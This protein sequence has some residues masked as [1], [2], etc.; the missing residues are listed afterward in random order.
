MNSLTSSLSPCAFSSTIQE[1]CRCI[2]LDE[3]QSSCTSSLS[4]EA[5]TTS[6]RRFS[7]KL[8]AGATSSNAM[9]IDVDQPF[10]RGPPT[11]SS[12]QS[13]SRSASPVTVA[14]GRKS[15]YRLPFRSATAP[16]P[17]RSPSPDLPLP[18]ECAFPV[19]PS[20]ISRSVTP[21]T[22]K[23]PPERSNT[24]SPAGMGPPLSRPLPSGHGSMSNGNIVGDLERK[25]AEVARLPVF[26]PQPDTQVFEG[27]RSRRPSTSSV[28]SRRKQSFSTPRPHP[29]LFVPAPTIPMIPT[30]PT[31]SALPLE[32]ETKEPNL[33]ASLV[34]GSSSHAPLHSDIAPAPSTSST[35]HQRML[36]H[37]RRPSATAMNRPLNEIGSMKYHRSTL[38]RGGASP[39]RL[40]TSFN[41]PR[42][43]SAPGH[44]N[45]QI[46]NDAPPVPGLPAMGEQNFEPARSASASGMWERRPFDPPPMP[47]HLRNENH[48]AA[49]N[50]THTPTE[51]TSSSDSNDSSGRSSSS[52]SSPPTS[53][54]SMSPNKQASGW[55]GQVYPDLASTNSQAPS[56]GSEPREFRRRAPAKSFSRPTYAAP[57]ASLETR[58]PR[59]PFQNSAAPEARE[60]QPTFEN[61]HSRSGSRSKSPRLPFQSE[62]QQNATESREPRLP[63]QSEPHQNMSGFRQPRLPFQSEPPQSAPAPRE[64]RLPFQSEPIQ[65][66]AIEPGHSSDTRRP[67]LTDHESPMDPAL[68]GGRLPPIITND[69]QFLPTS[70]RPPVYSRSATTPTYRGVPQLPNP[71]PAPL[72]VT[73]PPLRRTTTT[74]KGKCRG[75]GDMIVGK[76]VSS[77][78]GRLT[79]RWH[80]QC[81]ACKTCQEPFPTMDFYVLG[82]DP[83]CNRHYHQL[84]HSLCSNCDRGIE[85]QYVEA[86]ERKFHPH[87]LNCCECHLILR[88]NYFDLNG[89]IYCEKHAFKSDFLSAL[90]PGRR[91]PEKRSTRLMMM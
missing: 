69:R 23:R 34:A 62:P 37:T 60:P 18:Q 68:K 55:N 21:S 79:G 31:I 87:C 8:V 57:A 27:N 80:K 2:F 3:C 46:F 67:S 90:G 38:S 48:E 20:P 73:K 44:R 5:H 45:G 16:L 66:Q 89:K 32:R 25:A 1:V 17:P 70:Q 39:P 43:A 88:D 61:E 40:D 85:G 52:R 7:S 10:L 84:N 24:A 78:D 35:D 74:H 6:D 19:F 4:N 56:N 13:M 15:P 83:Y 36:M 58:E 63:F 64:P 28:D 22:L 14:S 72:N 86:N 9:L 77:A 53:A 81:F 54:L 47:S 42:S 75:C 33:P 51:S 59:L 30:I 29:D 71:V 76:S 49:S 50:P 82:N 12:L 41:P 91:F 26:A 11:P 65:Q